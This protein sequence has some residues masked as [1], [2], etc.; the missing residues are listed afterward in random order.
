LTCLII[1][2]ARGIKKLER[3]I[4]RDLYLGLLAGLVGFLCHCF[5]DTHLSSTTLSVF[6]FMYL[7]VSVAFKKVIYE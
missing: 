3:G 2:G 5:V 6:L 4:Y 1:S 7:G